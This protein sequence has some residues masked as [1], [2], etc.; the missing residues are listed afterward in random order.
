MLLETLSPSPRRT[1][2][3]NGVGLFPLAIP[4]L[5]AA[6]VLDLKIVRWEQVRPE[7]VAAVPERGQ[8][9]E[10]PPKGAAA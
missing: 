8:I 9:G 1:R 5:Y 7:G 3:Q 6:F 2:A 10:Q 4:T